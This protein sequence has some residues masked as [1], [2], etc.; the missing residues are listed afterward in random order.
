MTPG[1]LGVLQEFGDEH[2]RIVR[3]GTWS[4]LVTYR[5]N[6]SPQNWLPVFGAGVGGGCC[7]SKGLKGPKLKG[8]YPVSLGEVIRPRQISS[9]SF[10]FQANGLAQNQGVHRSHSFLSNS[11]TV[12]LTSTLR[13]LYCWGPRAYMCTI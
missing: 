6:L 13:E 5:N 3:A 11:L 1:L 12:L 9:L 8:W 2:F 4:L 7:G 10:S